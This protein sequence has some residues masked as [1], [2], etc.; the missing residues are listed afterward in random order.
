M[1]ELHKIEDDIS[2]DWIEKLAETGVVQI[3][4]YLAKHLAFLAFL[5]TDSASD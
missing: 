4:D 3:E 5:E 1:E 2:G